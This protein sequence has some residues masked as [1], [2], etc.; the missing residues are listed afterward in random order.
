MAPAPVLFSGTSLFTAQQAANGTAVIWTYTGGVLPDGNYR[1]TLPAGSISDLA[2]N[3]MT[4]DY[5]FDFFVLAGDANHDRVVDINDLST[6]ASN[7]QSV[8]K[9]FSQGDFNYDGTVDAKDLTILATNW[10]KYLPAPAPTLPVSMVRRP[11]VRT[12]ARAITLVT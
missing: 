3:P 9:V 5:T 8:G 11:A 12:P 4:A 2:G 1:A 7:W 10:Q 6:L